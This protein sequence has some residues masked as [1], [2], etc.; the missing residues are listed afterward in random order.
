MAFRIGTMLSWQAKGEPQEGVVV[1]TV[2]GATLVVAAYDRSMS[3]DAAAKLYRDDTLSDL[4]PSLVTDKAVDLEVYR[5][6]GAV[7]LKKVG[8]VEGQTLAYYKK[9]ASQLQQH[10][11]VAHVLYTQKRLAGMGT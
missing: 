1:G 2:A 3:K 9:L 7:K 11:A 4:L 5:I 10:E 6:P 8:E